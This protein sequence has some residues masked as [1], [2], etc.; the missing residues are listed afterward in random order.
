ML[1]KM[2]NSLSPSLTRRSAPIADA[3]QQLTRESRH[4]SVSSLSKKDRRIARLNQQ[5]S[6]SFADN[7]PD[8]SD[9]HSFADEILAAGMNDGDADQFVPESTSS[10]SNKGD[11]QRD[12]YQTI[13]PRRISM[14]NGKDLV[15][16]D[17][18]AE[19]VAYVLK[20]AVRSLEQEEEEFLAEDKDTP[21]D[22]DEQDD[23]FVDLK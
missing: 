2:K 15:Y 19:I 5:K 22:H 16:Q 20:H 17:L 21:F 12:F 9:D 23:D 18:S 7:V 3:V 14:G 4:P 8:N 11:F 10:Q 13:K 6:V 1:D